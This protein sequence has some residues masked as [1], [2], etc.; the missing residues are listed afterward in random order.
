MSA[1]HT[2][3]IGWFISSNGSAF[4]S[5]VERTM[6]LEWSHENA[7]RKITKQV[8]VKEDLRSRYTF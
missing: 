6:Y 3:A 1:W 4:Q 8:G 2:I 5:V 7:W